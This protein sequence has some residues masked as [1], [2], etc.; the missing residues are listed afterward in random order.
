MWYILD[1]N[2]SIPGFTSYVV[3]SFDT[4]DEAIQSREIQSPTA[5]LMFSTRPVVGLRDDERFEYNN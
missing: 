2:C 3:A 1:D 5:W 4:E